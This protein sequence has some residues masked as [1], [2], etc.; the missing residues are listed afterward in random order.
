MVAELRGRRPLRATFAQARADA[1]GGGGQLARMFADPGPMLGRT[2]RD[3]GRR[4]RG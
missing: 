2:L 4:G 1:R 3:F